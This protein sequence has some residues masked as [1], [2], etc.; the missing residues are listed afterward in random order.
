MKSKQPYLHS[1]LTDNL[2]ISGPAFISLAL[3][4][5]FP[6]VFQSE[7]IVSEEFWIVLIVFID[8]AHV[9]GTMFRTYLDRDMMKIHR[10]KFILIPV[11]CFVCAVLAYGIGSIVFWRLMAY[12]AVFHFIRQQYGFMRLYSRKDIQKGF[13]TGIDK[14]AIYSAT[15]YPV[16][17]W[18]LNSERNFNWF[19]KG[20]FFYFKSEML[21][22]LA[23]FIYFLILGTYILSEINVFI[24]TKTFNIPKNLLISGTYLSWYAGIITFNSDMAF[25]TLNVISH[26]IPYMTL[27]WISGHKRSVGSSESYNKL[28]RTVFSHIG[29][30]VFII[31]LVLPAF[32]E[33]G[34]WDALVWQD[35]REI[36]SAFAR[37]DE[38]K[39]K[40][41]LNLVIPLLALPQITH[42]VLDGFIWK[43]SDDRTL[44]S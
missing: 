25:T 37:F 5:F 33:E 18:H 24:R 44:S 17:H 6:Q 22:L 21:L 23:G 42:Y 19:V 41:V 32:V 3:V 9:Y 4:F 15:I 7:N 38:I 28:I 36:F 35:H 13:K 26:G 30:P 29:V 31:L 27:I 11:L 16:L 20:D 34:L 14:L 10:Q 2:M 39:D 40:A 8:V 1:A 43:I 12:L